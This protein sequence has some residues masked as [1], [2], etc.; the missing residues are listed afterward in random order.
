MTMENNRNFLRRKTRFGI[1]V[2]L[3][4]FIVGSLVAGTTGLGYA[5]FQVSSGEEVNIFGIVFEIPNSDPEPI[6]EDITIY[7]SLRVSVDNPYIPDTTNGKAEIY[8]DTN[9]D[10]VLDENDE[11]VTTILIPDGTGQTIVNVEGTYF[12]KIIDIGDIDYI[13]YVIYKDM[14]EPDCVLG[15]DMQG[16]IVE[17][18]KLLGFATINVDTGQFISYVDYTIIDPAGLIEPIIGTSDSI[19]FVSQQLGDYSMDY[20]IVQL[21][22]EGCEPSSQIL[23]FDDSLYITLYATDKSCT[24]IGIQPITLML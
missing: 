21:E 17:R 8:Y 18:N 23:Q 16:A 14:P 15:L 1:P 4:L 2:F 6:I 22:K 20:I 13:E 7:V 24:T 3:L 5:V 12:A 11:L 19:G 9:D 10:G